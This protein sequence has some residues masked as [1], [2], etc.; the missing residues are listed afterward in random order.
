V[1]RRALLVVAWI[2]IALA[3]LVARPAPTPGPFIRDFEA[4]WSA[5][6]AW[7]AGVDPYGRG[8][9][10]AERTIPQVDARRD[11]VLPFVGPPATLL[12]WS[13]FARLRYVAAGAVWFAALVLSLLLL[14]AA[15]VRASGAPL[16]AFAFCAALAAA[17]ACGP[18]TSDLALGQIA[19]LAFT[20]AAVVALAAERSLP[21]ATVAACVAF[22]QPNVAAG[23][24]SQLGRNRATLAMIVGA[25]VTYALGAAA[26]G[27]A[28][29]LNLARTEAA[30]ALAE[31]FATIQVT[32]AA[33]AYG[34]GSA[35]DAHLIGIAVTVLAIVAAIVV[36]LRL[37]DRYARFAA[38]SVL[39]P[40]VA[41]FFHEHDLVVTYAA[42]VWCAVRTRGT[43]RAVAL[44]GS[45]LA[46]VDWLGLSQRP[47]GITQS[48]LLAV[49]ACAAFLA[50]GN[51]RMPRSMLAVLVAVA[52][53]FA[54]AAWLAAKHPAP[55]WP[56]TL[57]PFHA[58][59]NAS[60]AA[61]WAAEQQRSGLLR[62]VPAWAAL[63]CLSLLGCGLL[64]YAIYR[65]SSCC[66]T[67]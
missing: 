50:L 44:A 46:S 67:A 26:A 52:G 43:S 10:K 21:I 66:R 63:R 5:G 27:W 7:N 59:Q 28:W 54:A 33:I 11:E 13:V 8:I 34:F 45:L 60:I 49:A 30:H 1:T 53:V 65:H 58:P 4:Y 35:K 62:I 36:A 25:I 42:I 55:V 22:T 3:I 51:E 31:R 19:L 12:G 9:W 23:L 48:A 20:G 15:A 64:A 47:S 24:I 56:D 6:S 37:R 61:V 16:S 32:P 38:F 17:I 41:A 29:P 39:V 18:V 2:A 57:G 40:F 14:A